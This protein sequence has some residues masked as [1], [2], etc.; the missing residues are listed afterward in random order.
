M[1]LNR[2]AYTPLRIVILLESLGFYYVGCSPL[3]AAL[4]KGEFREIEYYSDW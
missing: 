4:E 2:L 3:E 1:D